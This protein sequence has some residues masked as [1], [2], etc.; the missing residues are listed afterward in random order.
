M[1]RDAFVFED[2]QD[3][4]RDVLVLA[5]GQARALLD[6]GDV[7]AETA[8]HLREF[9]RDVAAADDDQMARQ[10]LE[11]H[12]RGIGQV[13]DVVDTGQIRHGSPAAGVEEDLSGGQKVVADAHCIGGFEARMAAIERAFVHT[14]DPAFQS[15]SVAPT[16]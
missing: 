13:V 8:E 12:H 10:D 4:G 3:G 7:R 16:S 2:R 11:I 5:A 1:D 9:E 6:D 15:G 14:G